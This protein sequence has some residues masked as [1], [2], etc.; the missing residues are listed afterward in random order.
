MFA[1]VITTNHHP[2]PMLRVDELPAGVRAEYFD[3]VNEDSQ[4]GASFFQYRGWWYDAHEFT[5]APNDLKGRGWDG[6][7]TDSAWSGIAVQWFDA[8]G[9]YREDEIVVASLYWG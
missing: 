2:R 5:V 8:D 6:V 7:Q 1:T 9:E 4:D 3:Y